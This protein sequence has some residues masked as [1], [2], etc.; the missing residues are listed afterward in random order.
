[1]SRF[2]VNRHFMPPSLGPVKTVEPEEMASPILSHGPV[3]FVIPNVPPM[4]LQ[5]ENKPV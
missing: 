2:F 4:K 5:M 3:I 1:M